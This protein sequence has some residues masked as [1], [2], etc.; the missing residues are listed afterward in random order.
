M[1]G[2]LPRGFILALLVSACTRPNEGSVE[3]RHD[4][5]LLTETSHELSA[6]DSLMWQRPDSALMRLLPYFDT[7]RDDV[8]TVSTSFDRH[9]ANLLLAEL[10]YKNDYIQSNR[11]ELLQAVAYFDSLRC[12]DV[13][14]HFSTNDDL[15]FL[16]A[17]AHYINGVGYYENGSLVEACGEYLKA[18]DVMERY[19]EETEMVGKKA[20]FIALTYTHLTDMFS[21]LYLHEQAIYFGNMSI[22]YYK[23]YNV[24]SWNV[25]WVYNKIGSHHDMMDE[26]DSAFYYYKKAEL[27]MQD[28]NTLMYRDIATHLA[29][30]EYKQYPQKADAITLRLQSLLSKSESEYECM[31]RY[32][33]IGDV[34][35]HEHQF[36]SAWYYLY[37]V[38]TETSNLETKKQAAEW[39]V[40]I[41]KEQNEISAIHEYATFLVP[42]AS[43]EE[44][45]SGLKSMLTE[46]YN[47]FKQKEMQREYQDK[48]KKLMRYAMWLLG[49]LSVLVLCAFFLYRKNKQGKKKLEAQMEAERQTHRIQQ[50]ALGERLRRSKAALRD[51][52]AQAP[53]VFPTQSAHDGNR[54]KDYFDEPICQQ[55]LTICNDK[56]NPIKS[57]VPIISYSDI[58]LNTVQKAQLKDAALCHYG[59]LFE[60]LKQQ[61]P[62]LKEKDFLYCYLSLL[63][64]D[65]VQIAALLQKSIST[66]WERE[67][68]LKRILGSKDDVAVTLN[69][70]LMDSVSSC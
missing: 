28:T 57:T 54:A 43:Q 70:L 45:N 46:L 64:L 67:N 16:D 9:Y 14:R 61:H 37:K 10:L 48:A 33:A 17:R 7:C 59:A 4:T 20:Q 35:Y 22:G 27:A 1:K 51:H 66:I 50:A 60:K 5:S 23:R 24:D 56:N 6:I 18:L 34:F 38:Y 19:C 47:T 2:I 21:G 49:V 32:M 62:E 65:N 29:C 15:V 31:A 36:D 11:M 8:H 52:E 42:F 63:G 44:D 40:D 55:I 39:L 12:R 58:A 68:R 3:T 69:L 53:L 13:A 30:L 26:L 41:C 25:A